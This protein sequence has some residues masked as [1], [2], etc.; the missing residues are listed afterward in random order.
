LPA[1][2]RFLSRLDEIDGRLEEAEAGES[3]GPVVDAVVVVPWLSQWNRQGPRARSR[4]R[5]E[6][7]KR[8]VLLL[9]VTNRRLVWLGSCGVRLR[10]GSRGA[11]SALQ[12]PGVRQTD[13][14]ISIQGSPSRSL[15]MARSRV[16]SRT[17]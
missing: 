14:R 6:G 12:A 5:V 1:M 8:E 9:R 11:P 15:A 17:D 7:E 3:S 2:A 10:G 13:E 16:R 4:V